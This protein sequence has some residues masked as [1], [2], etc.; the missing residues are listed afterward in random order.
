[1]VVAEKS[2]GA[3]DFLDGVQGGRPV[4][5]SRDLGRID[6]QLASLHAD[7]QVVHH[8]LEKLALSRFEEQGVL[9][10]QIKERVCDLF[11][12]GVFSGT[13]HDDTVIHVVMELAR[14]LGV[15]GMEDLVEHSREGCRCGA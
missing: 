2:K 5:D 7:A 9:F 13:R 15:E 4:G 11:V 1:M 12:E 6:H 10:Q 8:R 14:I 3:S